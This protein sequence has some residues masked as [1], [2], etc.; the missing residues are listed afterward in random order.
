MGRRER[1]G[2]NRKTEFGAVA[3]AMTQT[4]GAIEAGTQPSL[5]RVC[6][7][8]VTWRRR[9]RSECKTINR[10]KSKCL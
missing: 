6:A 9:K 8:E 10:P 2:G 1:I 7:N 3:D 4:N 5:A